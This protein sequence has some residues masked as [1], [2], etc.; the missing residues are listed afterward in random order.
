MLA[1]VRHH[2]LSSLA[3]PI[4]THL[5]GPLA[6][7]AGAALA[8]GLGAAGV[9]VTWPLRSVLFFAFMSSVTLRSPDVTPVPCRR[10]EATASTN[11]T[12]IVQGP[13]G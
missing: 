6:A 9:V 5:G 13:G 8:A 3:I 10:M 11:V 7:A 2:S 1:P 4:I 12:A